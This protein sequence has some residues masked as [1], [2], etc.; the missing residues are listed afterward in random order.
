MNCPICQK[1]VYD[2]TT[3][4]TTIGWECLTQDTIVWG[5][6]IISTPH[7][8][9]R[10]SRTEINICPFRVETYASVD[11]VGEYSSLYHYTPSKGSWLKFG[12]CRG[13]PISTEEKMKERLR[14]LLVFS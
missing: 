10:G 9:V 8:S 11:E 3:N 2:I 4:G 5:D 14:L 6:Q 12:S 13:W 1:K 7:Y